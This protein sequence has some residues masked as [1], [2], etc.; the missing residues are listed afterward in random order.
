MSISKQVCESEGEVLAELEET[1]SY[2]ANEGNLKGVFVYVASNDDEE[3]LGVT[4]GDIDVADLQ[5]LI[6]TIIESD[7]TEFLAS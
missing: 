7:V 6:H 3:S 2:L 4:F 5:Q 1:L